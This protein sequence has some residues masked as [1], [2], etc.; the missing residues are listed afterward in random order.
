MVKSNFGKYGWY[1]VILSMCLFYF[2]TGLTADGQNIYITAFADE[3]G[4]N[5]SSQFALISVSGYI[6]ICAMIFM[7]WLMGKKGVR[8][9][10]SASLFITAGAVIFWGRGQE[11]YQYF[12]AVC[13]IQLFAV[14]SSHLSIST[15]LDSF[16]PK[17]KGIVLGW[18]TMGLNLSTIAAVPMMAVLFRNFGLQNGLTVIGVVYIGLGILTTTTIRNLPEEIGMGPD[19]EPLSQKQL[20]DNLRG[21]EKY[22]TK[23]RMIDFLKEREVWCVGVAGGIQYLCT[24]GIIVQFVPR[25]IGFGYEENTAILIYSLSGIV[26]LP[27]SYFWGWLDA[28]AGVRKA[29]IVIMCWYTAAVFL[30]VISDSLVVLV[31][32]LMMTFFA[33]GGTSTIA[34]SY[35][36]SVFGRHEFARVYGIV[37]PMI[38]ALRTTAF[39]IL[40]FVLARYGNYS[41]AYTIFLV[42]AVAGIVVISFA[43]P[44]PKYDVCE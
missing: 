38:A 32:G 31:A 35:M 26:G 36:G 2:Q 27:G 18:A 1:L 10:L 33:I 28:K 17:R 34:A 29:S 5:A 15:L 24:T 42:C 21:F 22:K 3:R 40:A 37:N 19:N 13:L 39:P 9:I 20:D 25:V 11:P 43:R 44:E 6:A 7:G 30:Y 41:P 8:L 4:W 16:F 12:I 14:V 23:W